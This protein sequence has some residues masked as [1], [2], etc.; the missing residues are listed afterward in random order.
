MMIANLAAIWCKTALLALTAMERWSAT[1]QL[2]SSPWES[3]WLIVLG[4]AALIIFVVS[5]VAVS[6]W[7][8]HHRYGR[9]RR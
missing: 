2:K 4:A 5:A 3:T 6:W 8:G 9:Q 1:R 7:Q